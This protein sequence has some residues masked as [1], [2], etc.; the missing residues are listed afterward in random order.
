MRHLA[1][2]LCLA[3]PLQALAAT[4]A[5]LPAWPQ[6]QKALDNNIN[7]QTAT[8]AVELEQANRDRWESG[9]HEFNLRVGTAQRSIVNQEKRLHEWDVALERAVRMPN[10]VLI[11]YDIGHETVARAEFA[12]G[13]ARH[14][15]SRTLL[16]LWFVWLREQAQ[17]QQWQQQADILQQQVQMTD[18]RLHAGDAPRLELN[19]AKAAAAQA[20]V[21]LQQA[22]VRAQLA[23]HE[24]LR[25]FPGLTLPDQ[26]EPGQPQEIEHD[27][28]YW[29]EHILSDSHELGM[30]QSDS[31]LLR[32]MAR[33]SSADRL[34]DPTLGVRHSNE[35]GGNERVTGV[36][37]TVPFSFGVRGAI[38]EGASR[39]A[40][41][42][43]EKE[44]AAQ[45][46]I[47]NDI[48]STYAQ[49]TGNYATWQQAHEAAQGMR[50]NAELMARAYAL[51]ESSLND[52]LM[53]RRLALE[54]SLAETIARL[55]ANESRYRLLLDAHLL[56]PQDQDEH[57]QR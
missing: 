8:T 11:D 10:K 54:S 39:Q 12:L 47:E 26:L 35:M 46:R 34:A 13:D 41:I 20:A 18:K 52:V 1:A 27:L 49:A 7:V 40:E 43:A 48:A 22:R 25:Q 31:R 50:E 38:A 24:L 19:Q 5:D 4:Y 30:L 28:G 2:L 17:M 55:D 57:A 51:G 36:Y 44:V 37:L 42:G 33:R 32:L 9:P 14:E 3:L 21:S 16:R 45:R 29:R 56:W 53:A 15:A 23:A 6:V